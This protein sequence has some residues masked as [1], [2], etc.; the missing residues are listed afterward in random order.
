MDSPMMTTQ[1]AFLGGRLMI[2]QPRSGYR[3]GLDPVLLAASIPAKTGQS[4]LELG[5]G[6]G[7]ALC[8]L[9]ARIPQLRLWGIERQKQLAQ[10]ARDNLVRNAVEGSIV[11]ADLQSPPDIL[12]AQSFDH[13]LANPPFFDRT[14]GTRAHEA[15]KE[16][17][18]GQDTPLQLWVDFASKRL[19]PQGFAHFLINAAQLPELLSAVHAGPFAAQAWP[20]AARAQR[21]AKTVIVR[22]RKGG[23]TPFSLNAPII[24][25][26]GEAHAGDTAPKYHPQIEEVL[27]H[28]AAL[29]MPQRS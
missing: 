23:K 8:C 10:L 29:M 24:L 15:T 17:G 25:H 2:E 1:D 22:L 26:R 19:V 12:R 27:R 21:P 28:G 16:S 4:I 18:R 6:V 11:E 20:I 5:C 13:I 14:Q 3:A 7:T 9:A